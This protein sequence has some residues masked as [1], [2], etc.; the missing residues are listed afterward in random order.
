MMPT[1][2]KLVAG[3]CFAAVFAAASY[4]GSPLFAEKSVTFPRYFMATNVIVAFLAGWRVLGVRASRRDSNVVAAGLSHGLTT[5]AVGV[6]WVL[7]IHGGVR[8]IENSMRMR[9]EGV[10]EAVVDVFNRMAEFGLILAAPDV[11]AILLLGAM[12]SGVIAMFTGAKWR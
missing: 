3:I 2:A 1:A 8:M 9:Y 11:L 10:P 4:V 5:L 7:F 12:V 6:F